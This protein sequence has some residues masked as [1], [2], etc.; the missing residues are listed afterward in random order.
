MAIY[1]K[2]ESANEVREEL[3]R[4]AGEILIVNKRYREDCAEKYAVYKSILAEIEGENLEGWRRFATAPLT[5]EAHLKMFND[6]RNASEE[7]RREMPKFLAEMK[8]PNAQWG[9]AP[10][11]SQKRPSKGYTHATQFYETMKEARDGVREICNNFDKLGGMLREYCEG[12]ESGYIE[13]LT[14]TSRSRKPR[15]KKVPE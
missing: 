12:C 1:G 8:N 7:E 11:M 5:I 9:N 13:I 6:Y 15:R 10:R 14:R 3:A 4:I 2:F